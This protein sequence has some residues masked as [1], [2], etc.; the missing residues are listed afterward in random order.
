M[1]FG[2]KFPTKDESK[3]DQIKFDM[4]NVIDYLSNMYYTLY[5]TNN[6]NFYDL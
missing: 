1:V 5:G 4:F 2:S 3:K 6:Y